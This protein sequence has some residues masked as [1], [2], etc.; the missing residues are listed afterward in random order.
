MGRD[1]DRLVDHHHVVVVEE[2]PHAGDRLRGE[3]GGRLGLPEVDLQHRAG[4]QPVGLASD[5]A[6]DEDRA[7]GHEVGGLRP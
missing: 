2:D 5:P 6:V 1:A 7:P 3:R 4:Q